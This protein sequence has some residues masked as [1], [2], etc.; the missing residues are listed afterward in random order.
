MRI[1]ATYTSGIPSQTYEWGGTLEGFYAYYFGNKNLFENRGG[2]IQ[3]LEETSAPA[4]ADPP[5]EEKPKSRKK[6]AVQEP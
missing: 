6:N 3:V 1:L 2:T 4:A 5:A